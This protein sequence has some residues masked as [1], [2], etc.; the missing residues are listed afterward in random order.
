MSTEGLA[1][2]S[3]YLALDRPD[4]QYSTKE[5]C[6]GMANPSVADRRKLKRLGWW[7]D[8]GW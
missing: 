4:I 1:A 3:N 8:L 2:R 5:V 7:K 6:R